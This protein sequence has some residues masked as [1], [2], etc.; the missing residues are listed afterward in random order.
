MK[1]AIQATMME[2]LVERDR[3]SKKGVDD[4]RIVVKL[5]VDHE[6]KDTHL[7]STA[8]VELDGELLVNGLLIPTRLLELNS[9]DFVLAD[10]KASLDTGNNKKG[11]E[12]GLS[13]E[14][15]EGGKTGLGVG[16][17]VSRGDGSW[18][19]VT[20]SGDDVSKDGKHG[21]TAVLGLNSAEASE[22]LFI[23]IGN[24]TKRIPETKRSLG[25]NFR[26]ERHLE[27]RRS[28]RSNW[29][30]GGG[31]NDGSNEDKSTEHF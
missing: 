29:G 15:R 12:D 2:R 4:V 14:I 11:S 25:T 26:L 28:G 9:L 22:F 27:G 30:E 7:G 31:T 24:K 18:D 19:S 10:S 13:W 6:A 1:R 20:S 23:S 21:D 17:I 5:L 8:V 16:E 3:G